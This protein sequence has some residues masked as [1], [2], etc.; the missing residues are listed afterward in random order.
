MKNSWG[1]WKILVGSKE[2]LD[3]GSLLVGEDFLY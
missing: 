1:I 2:D 3:L